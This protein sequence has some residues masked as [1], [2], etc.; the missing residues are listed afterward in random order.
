MIKRSPVPCTNPLYCF[1]YSEKENNN[2]MKQA[3]YKPL[4]RA[5][6]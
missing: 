2:D 4:Y 3:L 6:F 5:C 1:G